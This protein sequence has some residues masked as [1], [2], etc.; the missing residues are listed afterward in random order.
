MNLLLSCIVVAA[1]LASP[2]ARAQTPPLPAVSVEQPWA[3]ATAPGG[4]TGA[5]YLTILAHGTAD[6]L[7]G[8]STPVAGSAELHQSTS[9][10][11][12]AR[13]HPVPDGLALPPEQKLIL[14]PGGLH[15]MLLDLTHPLKQGD[16]FPLTL[17]FAHSAPL[18]VQVTVQAA[19]ASAASEHQ[20]HDGHAGMSM[21]PARP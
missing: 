17:T 18:T 1:A 2:Y 4:T 11:G 21:A 13:M 9:E 10:A 12:V 3:R 8:A 6:R 20:G 5:A 16:A 19:G 7:T 14:A 15:V